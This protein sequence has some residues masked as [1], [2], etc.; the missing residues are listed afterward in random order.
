MS[1]EPDLVAQHREKVIALSKPGEALAPGAPSATINNPDWFMLGPHGKPVLTDERKALHDRLIAEAFEDASKAGVEHKAIVLAGP[2]GAGKSTILN[3]L[4]GE[5]KDRYLVIDADNFKQALLR[6][7]VNDGSYE[8]KIKPDAIKALEADGEKFFPLELAS[9]VHE[10]SS[11]LATRLRDK[12]MGEGTNI[13]IDTVLASEKSAQK[14]SEGLTQNGYEVAVVDVEVPF[15]ISKGRIERRWEHSYQDALNGKDELGGRWVPS[16][17]A[18]S[19]Y[20]EDGK[21]KPEA[22]AEKL[23]RECPAVRSFSRYRTTQEGTATTPP[24]GG[25]EKRLARSSESVPWSDLLADSKKAAGM[26]AQSPPV[27]K[28]I[29][30]RGRDGGLGR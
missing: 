25:W 11:I 6:E 4:L 8:T 27:A 29:M 22:I 28:R 16:E 18:R 10:E 23:A 5:E 15:E 3:S 1:L 26:P 7:A 12:A 17:Y 13:I 2:P 14:I 24:V 19:V 9:L 30:P 20:G 21:S